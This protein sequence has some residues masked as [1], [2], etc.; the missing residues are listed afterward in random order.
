MYIYV[1][2]LT[3]LLCPSGVNCKLISTSFHSGFINL[4]WLMSWTL[5]WETWYMCF[6]KLVKHVWKVPAVQFEFVHF[7]KRE[8]KLK[9]LGNL[10]SITNAAPLMNTTVVKHQKQHSFSASAPLVCA[11]RSQRFCIT[12]CMVVSISVSN[13]SHAVSLFPIRHWV[14]WFRD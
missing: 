9:H 7:A 11:I 13:N 14:C 4:V 5:L 12:T 8:T 3:Y 10:T 6:R 1:S 2:R